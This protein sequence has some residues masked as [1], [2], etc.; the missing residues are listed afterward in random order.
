[1]IEAVKGLHDKIGKQAGAKTS[2]DVTHTLVS[3]ILHSLTWRSSAPLMTK[4]SV[5]WKAAQLT[6]LSCPS[7][8]YLTMASLPP[9][10]GR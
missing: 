8:T 5:G 6:P 2:D 1:M 3:F 10:D 4:G 9:G 7:S